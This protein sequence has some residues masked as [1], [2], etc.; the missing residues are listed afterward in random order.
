MRP[1][2]LGIVGAGWASRLHCNAMKQLGGFAVRLKTIAD[3]FPESAAK[4]QKEYGFENATTRFED[5]LEDPEIDA[6]ILCTP[7]RFHLAQSIQA[8]KA[9]KNVICEKPLNGYFGEPEDTKP[10]GTQVKK[11]D[12]YRKVLGQLDEL[13][14]VVNE[15][16][17]VFCYAENYIYSP[18]LRKAA[19]L[20]AAKGSSV[21]YIRAEESVRGSISAFGNTWENIGGGTLMRIGCHPLGGAVYIKQKEAEAKGETVVPVSLVADTGRMLDGL[22]EAERKYI[23]PELL[24][25]EDFATVTITFSDNS[26]VTVFANDNALGGVQNYVDIFLNDGTLRCR[27]TPTDDLDCYFVDDK[28]L[29]NTVISEAQ[30]FKTGWNKAFVS[31][32]IHRGYVDQLADFFNCCLDGTQPQSGFRQA[33]LICELIHAAYV[34]AEEGVRVYPEELKRELRG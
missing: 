5:I 20:I 19:E 30:P 10:V 24:D 16:G 28:G 18:N 11:R 15:S 23:R 25:V 4:L 34:S 8:L 22:T 29:E 12:M 26:K 2:C 32:M 13:E 17:K 3:V 7:P 33:R 1:I 9:G 14:R 21:T 31:E 6:V 27:I